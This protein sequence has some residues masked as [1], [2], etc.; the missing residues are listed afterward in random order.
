MIG[1]E[2]IILNQHRIYL[3]QYNYSGRWVLVVFFFLW[4]IIFFFF[5]SQ[6]QLK[7]IEK[8]YDLI[9]QKDFDEITY[10]IDKYLQNQQKTYKK[11]DK[12]IFP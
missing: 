5:C 4:F 2:R 1:I 6:Q 9:I 7:D 10:Q 3:N 11:L 8:E 12:L